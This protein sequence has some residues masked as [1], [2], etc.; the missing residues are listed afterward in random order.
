[1]L[2]FTVISNVIGIDHGI[3]SVLK[4]QGLVKVFNNDFDS[5]NKTENDSDK[6][7]VFDKSF[8]KNQCLEHFLFAESL[9]ILPFCLEY[10]F[11]FKNPTIEVLVQPPLA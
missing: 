6:D 7:D 5:N 8:H 11:D 2:C 10:H 4:E 3:A 9:V 1:M